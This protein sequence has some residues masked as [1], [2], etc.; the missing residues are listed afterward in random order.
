MALIVELSLLLG[1]DSGMGCG[2]I[3]ANEQS[4]RNFREKIFLDLKR[5][6]RMRC[7]LVLFCF[8]VM[9]IVV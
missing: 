2:S 1:I 7:F 4:L 8:A 3:L 5:G 9:D 6:H